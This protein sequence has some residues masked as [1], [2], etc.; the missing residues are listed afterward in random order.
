MPATLI[1]PTCDE[2][3]EA[4]S[5]VESE[6]MMVDDRAAICAGDRAEIDI[7]FPLLGVVL[8]ELASR[9][10]ARYCVQ[11]LFRLVRYDSSPFEMVTPRGRT[12][13][14]CYQRQRRMRIGGHLQIP[15]LV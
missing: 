11:T 10:S 15:Q 13:Y 12:I 6:D 9:K 2:L 3:K 1:A 5:V 14:Q 4:M 7:I 8:T